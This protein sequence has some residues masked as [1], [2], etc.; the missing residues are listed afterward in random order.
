LKEHPVEV[1]KHMNLQDIH[2]WIEQRLE[3]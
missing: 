2:N 1:L 3:A